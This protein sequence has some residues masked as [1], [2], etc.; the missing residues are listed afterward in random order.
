VKHFFIIARIALITG[1]KEEHT[2]SSPNHCNNAKSRR[3]FRGKNK[4]KFHLS[5][6]DGQYFTSH[7]FA[8][9]DSKANVF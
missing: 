8:T 3:K 2:R 9:P 5:V 1:E 6:S 4:I 7:F